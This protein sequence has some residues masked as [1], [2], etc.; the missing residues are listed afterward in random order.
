MYITRSFSIFLRL[1][2]GFF[3]PIVFFA[4]GIIYIYVYWFYRTLRFS[5][6]CILSKIY[7]INKIIVIFSYA[8]LSTYKYVFCTSMQYPF[9]SSTIRYPAMLNIASYIIWVWRKLT[10][11][12]KC[13]H[14]QTHHRTRHL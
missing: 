10:V 8:Y 3:L 5:A 7:I 6:A 4:V 12:F 9:H 1:A 2:T 11:R 13:L 14:K